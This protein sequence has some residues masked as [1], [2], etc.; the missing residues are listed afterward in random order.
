MGKF[1]NA[2]VSGISV[3]DWI[4]DEMGSVAKEDRRKKAAEI[5]TRLVSEIIPMVQGV[6][7]MP[8][9]WSDIVVEVIGDLKE[10]GLELAMAAGA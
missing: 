9:G 4:I 10:N 7:F 1:M 2:R 8:L 6:H 3:P 5:T